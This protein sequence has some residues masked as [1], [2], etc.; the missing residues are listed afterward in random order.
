MANTIATVD[1]RGIF[2]KE[3]IAVYKERTFTT[4]FL[5]SFFPTDISNTKELSIQVERGTEKIAVDVQRG[6]EGN[7][8]SFSKS[9]EKLFVPPY[10]N[11][12]FDA[13]ELDFY[14]RL[15]GTNGDVDVTTFNAWLKTV[16]E[17][18]AML[19]DKIE[20]AYELQC[21]QV[22][23]TGIVQLKHGVNIDFKR[24]ATSLVVNIPAAFWTV[25][26]VS[27]YEDL[28]KAAVFLRTKGKVSSPIFDVIMADDV[29]SAFMN[30]PIVKER[31]DIKSLS[32]D[33]IR[34]PQKN[35][36]GGVLHGEVSAGAWKFR[37]WTYPEY[38]DTKV[39]ENIP[40][41][42]A[43]NMI[44]LPQAP[45]F[46]LGFAAV[47]RLLGK[48][49]DVGASIGSVRGDY[50]IGEYLDERNKAHVMEIMSAGVAIPV[51]VDTV[52]T[53]KVIA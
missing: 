10:Y 16:V 8:N 40:Y 7:R 43:G 49:S 2:T 38:Y 45:K 29:H 48:K 11:E 37:I 20:R 34:D 27:P 4:S 32:L 35:S 51:A 26:T 14:D 47:P 33:H 23:H 25:A 39:A 52:Y 15:F 1:A 31:N 19:K 3:L 44:V 42:T 6:T 46:M 5:R 18:I 13:T 21:A 41:M 17:K 36:S 12:F 53:A 9:S 50:V 24:K 28:K 30:N 22:L